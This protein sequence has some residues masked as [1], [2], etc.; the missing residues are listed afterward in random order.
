MSACAGTPGCVGGS[1]CG[2]SREGGRETERIGKAGT[3]LAVVP[4]T[5]S[6]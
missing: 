4:Q 2:G 3:V 5:V 1:A 6:I